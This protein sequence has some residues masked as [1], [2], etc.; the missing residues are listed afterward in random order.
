MQGISLKDALSQNQNAMK[1]AAKTKL[2]NT[3]SIVSEVSNVT[4]Q[5]LPPL[6]DQGTLKN[7][8]QRSEQTK[9]SGKTA[10]PFI[11]IQ[12]PIVAKKT[13]LN[14]SLA[15]DPSIERIEQDQAINIASQHS[16]LGFLKKGSVSTK[17]PSKPQKCSQATTPNN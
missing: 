9:N 7:E 5:N 15:Y 2:I 4:P 1:T 14:S 11:S 17:H 16:S 13:L 8:N 12:P 10:H 3:G 6:F